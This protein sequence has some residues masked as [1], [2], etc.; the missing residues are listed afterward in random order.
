MGGD[1][2][3]ELQVQIEELKEKAIPPEEQ[4]GMVPGFIL[5]TL[6]G[7]GY[8]GVRA[9]EVV[10]N[11]VA[12]AVSGELFNRAVGLP[13]ATQHVPR[14]AKAAYGLI[15]AIKGGTY[16]ALRESGVEE[17]V[18]NGV[19]NAVGFFQIAVA[20]TAIAEVPGIA[21]LSDEA[22][23]RA[24]LKATF[25][26]AIP[27]TAKIFASRALASG[28]KQAYY[29]GLMAISNVVGR[30]YAIEMSNLE[31]N[32]Q[33]PHGTWKQIAL[34]IGLPVAAGF[35]GGAVA[36]I[37][38]AIKEAGK[39]SKLAQELATKLEEQ[40][41][42]A[43]T[44]VTPGVESTGARPTTTPKA[45]VPRD[46]QN[47]I[48]QVRTLLSSEVLPEP[49]TIKT[50]QIQLD[51]I[52]ESLLAKPTPGTTKQLIE[53]AKASDAIEMARTVGGRVAKPIVVTPGIAKGPAVDSANLIKDET[54]QPTTLYH[55]S[56]EKFDT[57]DK[58]KSGGMMFFAEDRVQ[59]E[60][61]GDVEEYVVRSDKPIDLTHI[62]YTNKEV[63]NL[64]NDWA[65]EYDDWTDRAT[66]EERPAIDWIESGDLYDFEGTGSGRRWRSLFKHLENNGYDSVRI[67]DVTDGVQSPTVVVFDPERIISKRNA[68]GT[69]PQAIPETVQ[70]PVAE[71]PMA[72]ESVGG[73]TVRQ[74]AVP[75]IA[76]IE[77]T[78]ESYT[79]LPGTR[80]MSMADFEHEPY[81]D[82]RDLRQVDSLIE[83]ISASK[84]ISPIIVA[85]D[86][87]GPYI[88][89]GG[90]RFDALYK[91]GVDKF[92]AIVVI[93]ETNPPGLSA[94]AAPV[95]SLQDVIPSETM[96]PSN[97]I[98]DT[99]GQPIVLYHGTR[100]YGFAEFN[101]E[102]GAFFTADKEMA[103]SYTEA[104]ESQVT[105][106]KKKQ[107]IT[108]GVYSVYLDMKKPLDLSRY[109]A[110]EK[111]FDADAGYIGNRNNTA[112]K[113]SQLLGGI[114]DERALE[115]L[116][117]IGY[118]E[119]LFKNVY[120]SDP[121]KYIAMEVFRIPPDTRFAGSSAHNLISAHRYEVV[122]GKEIFQERVDTQVK[123]LL[124]E[125]GFDG[126]IFNDTPVDSLGSRKSTKTYVA[127]SPNQI[128]RIEA[129]PVRPMID[130]GILSPKGLE[131][132]TVAQPIEIRASV[133]S[134]TWVDD[135]TLGQFAGESW[136]KDE[137]EVRADVRNV[138]ITMQ[139]EGLVGDAQEFSAEMKANELPGQEKP[140][141]WYEH[142]W[143]SMEVQRAKIDATK[144]DEFLLSLTKDGLQSTLREIAD[145]PEAVANKSLDP[146]IEKAKA[147]M[148]EADFQAF[149][150]EAAKHPLKWRKAVET[151]LDPEARQA[152]QDKFAESLASKVTKELAKDKL[153][154]KYADTR[155]GEL[156]T[157]TDPEQVKAG[158]QVT[159]LLRAAT[160]NPSSA[161]D[162]DSRVAIEE[163]QNSVSLDSGPKVRQV[164][165]KLRSYYEKH[166]ETPADLA[167]QGIL[168][169]RLVGD[170]TVKELQDL[171]E[172]IDIERVKGKV[173]QNIKKIKERTFIENFKNRLMDDIQMGRGW[174]KN[175]SEPVISPKGMEAFEKVKGAGSKQATKALKGNVWQRQAANTLSPQRIFRFLGPAGD[176]A[177][178][179][180]NESRSME[181]RK[182]DAIL[183]PAAAKSKEL[184]ITPHILARKLT[185]KD[186]LDFT[187]DDVLAMRWA[188][189][190]EN[191][192]ETL[193]Y[194][195]NITQEQ[196]DD[197]TG[198]LRENEKLWGDYMQGVF[199]ADNYNRLARAY[200]E[201]M[202]AVPP[203][204]TDKY[205]PIRIQDRQY[206]SPGS[207]V[208]EDLGARAGVRSAKPNKRFM[209]S[210]KV[211]KPENRQRMRLGATSLF[212]EQVAKQEHY[213][214][215]WQTAKR[216][217]KIFM[218][219]PRVREQ[220]AQMFGD[221][222]NKAIAT[223]IN[224]F[225]NPN[226]LKATLPGDRF[227]NVARHG[228]TASGLMGNLVTLGYNLT[229]PLMYLGDAGPR[230]LLSA[231]AQWMVHPKQV[232]DEVTTNVPL[233]KHASMD[234]VIQGLK[235]H[236]PS[237][238]RSLMQLVEKVGYQPLEW[239]DMW[240]RI[241]GAKAVYD[242][243]ID[244]DLSSKDA[245]NEALLAT[246]RGQ[247]S[248]DP[249][250]LP[251]MYQ[252]ASL[253]IFL[254]FTR[255]INQIWN[256]YSAD[257]PQEIKQGKFLKAIGDV[258]AIALSGLFV[259]MMGQ[260]S[261]PKDPKEAALWMLDQFVVAIPLI[262]NQ[263]EPLLIGKGYHTGAEIIP[264]MTKMV[265]DIQ[266][267]VGERK[268]AHE[269]I[270]AAIRVALDATRFI[271]GPTVMLTRLYGMI[272]TGDPWELIGGPPK[273]R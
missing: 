18:A 186:G 93:D 259:A 38:G 1:K 184:G 203:P 39:I 141:A 55:G 79:I 29:A 190:D 165:E 245:W 172:Q 103:Q 151:G 243:G 208:S 119:Q 42:A 170:M 131:A 145:N 189:G 80:E 129:A 263:L 11:T 180:I 120:D 187:V 36:S 13:V 158:I 32:G 224:A 175:L 41:M 223:A 211:I 268:T 230:Y 69:V 65:S 114:S 229:G 247:P 19:A 113:L 143:D 152:Q 232:Y 9:G 167:T 159:K 128:H 30:E 20:S 220:I 14:G 153:L 264:G 140:P 219:D 198:Q 216:L 52:T 5:K 155:I 212:F 183:E 213:I 149:V 148:S 43:A 142:Q 237:A 40:R 130:Q 176:R 194:G 73:L 49:Q 261:M 197:L 45:I 207:E 33:I 256:M 218:V 179:M 174:K 254:A 161:I 71:Y 154:K 109:A 117:K 17:T 107:K 56:R 58:Q 123:E 61:Y 60:S 244:N 132:P 112:G 217:K 199:G 3:P 269:R 37:P 206:D 178:D 233:I 86:K 92:P 271:G 168:N 77:S 260:K 273:K 25:N 62:D 144:N 6:Y 125:L 70:G 88:L 34:G 67:M 35:V 15:G 50:V 122:K 195:N 146:W 201:E 24:A 270:D 4:L 74:G 215:T 160:K 85:V 225:A 84:E 171:A 10:Y 241:V 202:N 272:H 48:E 253:K 106:G 96:G 89:E 66:G 81:Y 246:Q 162:Y 72:Q 234:P 248:G 97:T 157:A 98:K 8:T 116:E 105:Q 91:M 242:K 228:L 63:Q 258:T 262:G 251:M 204:K 134:G 22:L 193:L 231:Q 82:A 126:I 222:W 7:L 83:Q 12:S 127:F 210:R 164:R 87:N 238:Y 182:N 53:I 196:F 44:N 75:N 59:A 133:K 169:Q 101:T 115:I 139:E 135:A 21:Q 236:N 205:F 31:T 95:R 110:E 250:D 111:I 252:A 137:L 265:T 27:S 177:W 99:E 2:S 257:I 100:S 47:P 104:R 185:T 90:H 150:V 235:N 57:F 76:S 136:A 188:D 124:E 64:I 54:G 26:G 68:V 166:P 266:A 16:R 192:R 138:A 209:I 156:T 51:Q 147:G 23:Y 239:I 94:E 214:N 118:N 267:L 121:F 200:V 102:H 28:T 249:A 163:L 78:L 221:D 255:Q 226:A 108:Q 240:T 173:I 191:S 46:I 181:W 227:A